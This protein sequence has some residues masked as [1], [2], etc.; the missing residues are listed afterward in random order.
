L[1]TGERERAIEEKK[2][3]GVAT[4]QNLERSKHLNN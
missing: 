3:D 1:R 2:G 4:L